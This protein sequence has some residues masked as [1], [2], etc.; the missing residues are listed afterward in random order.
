MRDEAWEP[1]EAP[2]DPPPVL[3]ELRR[4]A[5]PSELVVLG[6][7]PMVLVAIFAW[8]EGAPGP[9]VLS[10]VEP[11]PTSV[12]T[13]H[14]VHRSP[15]HLLANLAAYGF[16]APTAYV[17]AVLTDRGREYVAVLVGFLIALP[18]VLSLLIV[19]AFD[20]GVALGFSGVTMA[21][22]GTL[23]VY[24]GTY[25]EQR[26]RNGHGRSIAAGVF[27]LGLAFVA[28][29]AVAVTNHRLATVVV[30]IV[31]AL[32]YLW[33]DLTSAR[34]LDRYLSAVSTQEGQL[35][36]VGAAVFVVGLIA[37]FP[38]EPSTG[39]VEVNTFGHLVGYVAGF[40]LPFSVFRV[41]GGAGGTAGR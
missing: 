13:A 3:A 35:A 14:F 2:Q 21:L 17:L 34:G 31:I 22:V 4:R 7:I 26:F 36:T 39:P 24:L 11:T 9:F 6:G 23:A 27:F 12:V 40:V 20:R 37:G 30:T 41:V 28:S 5:R 18:P 8:F 32:F 29:R 38:L 1:L 16:V 33:A 10:S 15:S 25:V 19:F